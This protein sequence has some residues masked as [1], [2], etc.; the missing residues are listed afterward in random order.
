VPERC[1]GVF[2]AIQEE[3]HNGHRYVS[4]WEG[5]TKVKWRRLKY[6]VPFFFRFIFIPPL[7]ICV[8]AWR[9]RRVRFAAAISLLL[10]IVAFT[11]T[12]TMPRKL[13]PGACLFM[14]LVAAGLRRMCALRWKGARVGRPVAAAVVVVCALSLAAT[15]AP[16]M[17]KPA[18]ALRSP[19]ISKL[20]KE[21]GRHLVFVRYLPGHITHLEW[22]YNE[23]DIDN[24][25]I[26][27]A[28]ELDGESN[29][30]LIEYYKDR[31][32]W[33]LIGDRGRLMELRP[34]KP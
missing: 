4:T 22:V 24:S 14:F 10:V 7:V 27:W 20:E 18:F 5:F 26:V 33:L 28:R 15:F 11:E 16:Y 17:R 9:D 29:N 6:I 13:A 12:Q 32:P 1:R 31:R 21:E 8:F 2:R 34:G 23:A 30:R 3:I 25:R 19:V